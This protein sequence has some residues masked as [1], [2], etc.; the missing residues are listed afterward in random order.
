MALKNIQYTV[1]D[2][3]DLWSD[4]VVDKSIQSY[5][6]Q[7][8][9]ENSGAVALNNNIPSP[10]QIYTFQVTDQQ[11]PCLPSRSW[12][13]LNCQIVGTGGG[14]LAVNDPALAQGVAVQNNIP[15]FD[16]ARFYVNGNM[17][18]DTPN[19]LS[20][21][22]L[23]KNLLDYSFDDQSTFLDQGWAVDQ[24]DTT[25]TGGALTNCVGIREPTLTTY[26][27][28]NSAPPA[29]V[30]QTTGVAGAYAIDA[31]N[32]AVIPA[33]VATITPST[34]RNTAYNPGFV[35]RAVLATQNGGNFTIRVPLNRLIDILQIDKIYKG[36]SL[37]LELIIGPNSIR[38]LLQ[39][40]WVPTYNATLSTITYAPI[41][42]GTANS[43]FPYQMKVLNASWV[44]P[45]LTLDK[46]VELTLTKK[47]LEIPR[48]I[49]RYESCRVFQNS[50]NIANTG[51]S[52]T[53]LIQ[54][55]SHKLTKVLIGFT[56]A[57]TDL[58][59]TQSLNTQVF[60]NISQFIT[61]A[62]VQYGPNQYPRAHYKLQGGPPTGGAILPYMTMTNLNNRFLDY[63][64]GATIDYNTFTRYGYFLLPFDLRYTSVGESFSSGQ[65]LDMV[66]NM[67]LSQNG[68]TT[69]PINGNLN[70]WVFAF[71]EKDVNY[72]FVDGK[73]LVNP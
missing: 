29:N 7:F 12:V 30:A 73:I 46:E 72:S 67:Q 61:D 71:S 44:V 43:A 41:N 25:N 13:N 40:A 69:I 35:K 21:K 20:K 8:I 56:W 4:V 1:D 31:N 16:G 34:L 36:S 48:S 22:A 19:W 9:P 68:A 66:F 60:Q 64:G 57:N 55:A 18:D 11:T 17:A 38:Q 58:D 15:L 3:L 37:K 26:T 54:T 5:E 52:V 49:N 65:N 39:V 70:V 23:V 62:Y 6:Y 10:G 33:G 32:H 53:W 24:G 27:I 45:Y 59:A 63:E 2:V 14:A 28:T 50:F 42:A 47:M 51:G